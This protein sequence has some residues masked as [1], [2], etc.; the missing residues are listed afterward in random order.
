M[1][2][3]GAHGVPSR[4]SPEPGFR[5]QLCSQCSCPPGTNQ[6]PD[7]PG[8]GGLLGLPGSHCGFGLSTERQ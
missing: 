2:R 8:E 5:A 6:R 1:G 4:I 7:P 3:G